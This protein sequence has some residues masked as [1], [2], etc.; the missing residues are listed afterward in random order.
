MP[1]HYRGPSL[2]GTD[3][4]A[5]ACYTQC[6]TRTP[7]QL[8]GCQKVDGMT[9]TT[10]SCLDPARALVDRFL[11]S[12][13]RRGELQPQLL[14]VQNATAV[15]L[16]VSIELTITTP[17]QHQVVLISLPHTTR[18]TCR[19]GSDV[20]YGSRRFVL[21]ETCWYYT[22]GER[23]TIDTPGWHRIRK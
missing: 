16:P 9:F 4:A 10:A 12:A 13:V 1:F 20:L 21:I 2:A 7:A 17:H 18:G 3:L 6:V 14:G 11:A 15:P 22:G 19:V 23:I 8:M 5:G